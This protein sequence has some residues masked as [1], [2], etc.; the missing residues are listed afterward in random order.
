MLVNTTYGEMDDS[1]LEKKEGIFE[2]D[3]EKTS[4]VEYWKGDE[5]VHRSAHVIIKKPAI[6]ADG[7]TAIF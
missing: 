3:D 7:E 2:N 5:M 1:L 6:F 4:W